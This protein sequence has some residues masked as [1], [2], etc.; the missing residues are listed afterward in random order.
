MESNICTVLETIELNW[1]GR[2][3]L[4]E[5]GTAHTGM[6]Q[7]HAKFIVITSASFDIHV[8]S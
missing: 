7:I 8:G 1:K 6:K 3:T 5:M 4:V 2:N